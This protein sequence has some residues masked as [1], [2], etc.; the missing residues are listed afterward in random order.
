MNQLSI[1]RINEYAPYKVEVEDGQYIFETDHDILY[2][3]SFDEDSMPGSLKAY[4]FNLT[5]FTQ[6][7]SPRDLKIFSSSRN[8]S[9]QILTSCSTCATLPTTS[10]H[11]AAG[12]SSTGLTPTDSRATTTPVRRWWK[13]AMKRTTSHSSWSAAI[14][15][16]NRLLTCSTSRLLCSAPISRRY[17]HLFLQ[18][19]IR[20]DITPMPRRFVSVLC[21]R[22]D[23]RGGWYE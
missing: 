11:S 20:R 13:T 17:R 4:W 16:Y 19:N 10:R 21:R 8:S 23:G 1:E 14:P 12:C 3:V 22:A 15:N 7:S 2:G 5:N 18:K 6:K 9:A